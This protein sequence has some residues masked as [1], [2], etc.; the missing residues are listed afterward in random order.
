[1]PKKKKERESTSKKLYLQTE[2]EERLEISEIE[3][4]F[5][6]QA[7]T[8]LNRVTKELEEARYN[9]EK[10]Y[11]ALFNEMSS[12]V[13]VYEAVE[14]GKDFIF[15]EFNKAGEKI[16]KIKKPEVIGK[17]VTTVFPDVIEFGLFKVLQRVYK[18]GKPE[19]LPVKHYQNNLVQ[20]WRDNYV[21]KLPSGEIVMI[22]DD[23]TKEKRAEE[24]ILASETKLKIIT[25]NVKD[26]IFSKDIEGRYTFVNPAAAKMI[27]FSEQKILGKKAEELF[28]KKDS[29][30]IKQI[31][32]Q[33]LEGKMVDEIRSLVIQGEEHI[34][35][36][37]QVPLYDGKKIVGITG[38]ARDI[39][40]EQKNEQA[41]MESEQK[42][43][44]IFNSTLSVNVYVDDKG[45]VLDVNQRV[46]KV[47]GY[48]ASYF[49]GKKFLSLGNVFSKKSL[50]LMGKNFVLRFA[51]KQ[52]DPY[53]VEMI[54]KDGSKYI[55]RLHAVRLCGPKGKCSG[56]LVVLYDVTRETEIDKI[57]TEFVSIASHQLRT[58]LTAMRLFIEMLEDQKIGTLNPKQQEYLTNLE[59]STKRM[60]RL[61][62]D[63]LNASRLETGRISITPSKM[64]VEKMIDSIIKELIPIS[65]EHQCRV[66]F[67]KP[68][69]ALPLIHVDTDLVVQIVKNVLMNALHYSSGKECQ[70][71]VSVEKKKRK[72]E[73]MIEIRVKDNGIGIPKSAQSHIFTKFFRADNAIKTKT[74][75][76][77]LG[78]YV[79]KMITDLCEGE[80]AFESTLGLGTTFYISLP[81]K[82]VEARKGEA[83]I[84][85]VS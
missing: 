69:K 27:G 57:K 9:L 30:K 29:Q 17:K 42:Y 71:K 44:M 36:T 26:A 20:S 8:Q 75:G 67:Q 48:P 41:L 6:R 4:E 60:I 83:E 25:Q 33:N 51:G 45:K 74:E 77:G 80:I 64:Q 61:V 84:S 19:R 7:N 47:T 2:I 23:R 65:K 73:D 46:E 82:G 78:L 70:I 85:K 56:E 16:D 54:A 50:V 76:T 53:N 58:P 14:D 52:I 28:S 37:I 10:R 79:A 21:C 49:I 63:L 31:D 1:M 3:R 11:K 35:R 40:K 18:T 13:A 22:Y 38:V 39:T 34:L 81:V 55:Y 68:K 43:R 32:S 66:D 62:N 12:A 15:K 72:N 59:I 24:K 5:L